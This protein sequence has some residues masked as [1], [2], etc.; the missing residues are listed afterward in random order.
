MDFGVG[1][2][3]GEEERIGTRPI[4]EGIVGGESQSAF[5]RT[6]LCGRRT[7]LGVSRE[8]S[9]VQMWQ[10]GRTT[11]HVSQPVDLH[12]IA[13]YELHMDLSH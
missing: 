12:L 10:Q 7:M 2:G 6:L 3:D 11:G 1:G 4:Y 13:I 9:L 8:S 5:V